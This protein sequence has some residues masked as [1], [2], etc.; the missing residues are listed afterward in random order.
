M[1]T[2]I[3]FDKGEINMGYGAEIYLD[4]N[5]KPD[6][7][8]VE[9]YDITGVAN[10]VNS[11]F[12]MLAEC[13]RERVENMIRNLEIGKTVYTVFRLEYEE[14]TRVDDE[15]FAGIKRIAEDRVFIKFYRTSKLPEK[16]DEQ[17]FT[18]KKFQNLLSSEKNTYFDLKFDTKMIETYTINYGHVSVKDN[19][20]FEEWKEKKI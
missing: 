13:D 16:I 9:Y 17:A 20:P 1:H 8:N 7:G 14:N 2:I 19:M 18:I 4:A 5:Y 3:K 6:I 11:F 12:K 10:Y 15:F